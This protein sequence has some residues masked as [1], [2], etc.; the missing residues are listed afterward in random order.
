MT[1]DCHDNT[2]ICNSDAPTISC[3]P[4]AQ[5]LDA[6]RRFLDR[7]QPPFDRAALVTFDR[8]AT[9]VVTMTADLD[10][11]LS[12]LEGADPGNA[13]TV[14]N[15]EVPCRLAGGGIWQ[16]ANTNLGMGLAVSNNQF[17]HWSL[18][19]DES[20]WVLV[21][22]SDGGAN[23]ALGV[24]D[25]CEN[26]EAC[27]PSD[28]RDPDFGPPYCR[29]ADADTRHCGSLDFDDCVMGGVRAI[30]WPSGWSQA[31]TAY[32]ADDFARDMADF[33][34]LAPPLGNYIVTFAIGLGADVTSYSFGGDPDAGEKVLRYIANVGY[35]GKLDLG[36]SD[37]CQGI[38]SGQACGNYFFAPEPSGL[39]QIFEEIASRIFTRITR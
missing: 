4:M 33:V 11:V 21:L 12:I 20:V 16:C 6:S 27:C 32:D 13:V 29:D 37:L 8:Y 14:Y 5:V 36:A 10:Q 2:L 34:A 9:T 23:A 7:L 38:P 18:R 31:P 1:V 35:N 17:T 26:D 3:E 28:T 25:F 22:L 19:R 39:D 15:D 30:N 24:D